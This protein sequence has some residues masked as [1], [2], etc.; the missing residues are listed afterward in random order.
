MDGFNAPEDFERAFLADTGIDMLRAGTS[1]IALVL[2]STRAVMVRSRQL[3]DAGRIRIACNEG[4]L[5]LS[6]SDVLRQ[7]QSGQRPTLVILSD[8]LVSAHEATLLIRTAHG[9]IYVSPLEMILNQRYGYALAFWGTQ[10]YSTIDAHSTDSSVILHRI[11][12]HLHQCSSLGEQWLLRGEQ[13][14]RTPVIRT[15][16]AR[17][18]IRMFRSALLA[19]YQPNSVD[20]ELDALMEAV[21]TLEG[22]LADRLGRLAC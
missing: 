4:S 14:L 13:S 11:I 15:Y 22:E 10:G 18:K 8:Q 5:G 6:A 1:A 3:A 2:P 21:D 16:N 20:S 9:D 17:R 7:A 12:D 19:Q